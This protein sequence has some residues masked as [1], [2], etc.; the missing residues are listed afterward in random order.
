MLPSKY[1]FIL[2]T[3]GTLID[4]ELA[5]NLSEFS[6]IHVRIS[7]KSPTPEKWEKI[8]GT[9][10]EGFFLQMEAMR[11]LKKFGVPFHPA[12][13]YELFTEKREMEILISYL[14]E[15]DRNLPSQLEFEFLQI[16]PPLKEKIRW[17]IREKLIKL[18]V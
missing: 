10:E 11:H 9:S 4:K 16:L 17:G 15:I 1:T 7:L 18:R 8:T 2:E 13:M 14:L 5:K 12:I 3:N 6:N